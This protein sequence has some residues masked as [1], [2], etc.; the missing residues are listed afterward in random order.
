[1]ATTHVTLTDLRQRQ[2]KK[3][4]YIKMILTVV[5]NNYNYNI[6]YSKSTRNKRP[7]IIPIRN[8]RKNKNVFSFFN[9]IN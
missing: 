3:L 7:I 9:V 5:M 1:M 4:H 2:N 6:Y 8:K